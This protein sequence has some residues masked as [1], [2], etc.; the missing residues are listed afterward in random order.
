MHTTNFEPLRKATIQA[1]SL[2]PFES[3]EFNPLLKGGS[4]RYFYRLKAASRKRSWIAVC[5]GTERAENAL[6]ADI[7]RFLKKIEVPVPHIVA[8]DATSR[9][10]WLEDLGG[11]DLYFYR[12]ASWVQRSELYE[13]SIRAVSVLHGDG[14]ER[15]QASK[16]ELMPGFDEKLYAWERR[17]FY[18]EFLAGV[19]HD[20]LDTATHEQIEADFRPAARRLSEAAPELV[21]RDFQSQNIMVRDR[22]VVLIDF[23]GMRRGV[24][25]YDL[26]SLIFDPYVVF[27]TEEREGLIELAFSLDGGG[28]SPTDFR[29]DLLVAAAQRLMQALGAYGLLGLKKKKT[30]FLQHIPQ[31]LENLAWVLRS[32]GISAALLERVEKHLP[33]CRSKY[34]TIST[35]L[36][37]DKYQTAYKL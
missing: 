19:C 27:T 4:D 16:L 11:E 33:M 6:Y 35:T 5:Y 37:L 25:H 10:L 1:L 8:E 31:A 36:P 32:V 9:M 20:P 12:T 17:Y 23:Q 14:W 22:T 29:C 30:A 24:R 18:E 2:D 26:A 34:A 13:K 21:H 7:A 15:A 28:Q 3:L